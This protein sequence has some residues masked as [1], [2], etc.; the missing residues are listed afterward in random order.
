LTATE[1]PIPEIQKTVAEAK[2]QAQ[3]EPLYRVSIYSDGVK[4]GEPS[5]K[6]LI[7]ELGK[8]VGQMEGLLGKV[9][10][11]LISIQE[12]KDNLF[13]NLTT[14]KDRADQKP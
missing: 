5:N 1:I 8:T 6:N 9:D 11:G 2:P 3:D 12:K 7:T 4:K 14:K 10:D 13:A